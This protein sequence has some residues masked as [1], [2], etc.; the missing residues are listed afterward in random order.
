[1]YKTYKGFYKVKNPKKYKGDPNEV[2]YR[3]HW[4]KY[5]MLWCDSKSQ[6]V[7]WCSEEVVIPYFFELDQKTHRYFIDFYIKFKDG[8]VL[9]VEVKPEAQTK[10]PSGPKKT[11]K[12]LNESIAFVKNQAKWQAAEKVA[13]DQGWKFVIWTEK[14][15]VGLG[16]MPKPFK[17]Q[18]K[19]PGRLRSPGPYKNKRMEKKHQ[20]YK[21][22][23]SA[24]ESKKQ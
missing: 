23:G 19:A 9:L 7:Q 1:M 3:S 14:E 11:K 6:V 10:V 2:V 18:A 16:I 13:A 4:E 21:R 15:L 17:K 24:F 5:V 22:A 8:K 20:A 12:Y